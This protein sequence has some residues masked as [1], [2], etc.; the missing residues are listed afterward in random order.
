M[1]DTK[2]FVDVANVKVPGRVLGGRRC[3]FTKDLFAGLVDAELRLYGPEGFCDVEGK[4]SWFDAGF[5]SDSIKSFVLRQLFDECLWLVDRWEDLFVLLG[6]DEVSG[7]EAGWL[8]VFV[9][10]SGR[11]FSG[12]VFEGVWWEKLFG[13]VVRSCGRERHLVDVGGGRLGWP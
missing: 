13:F 1:A 12:S 3:E 2:F 4:P 6:E 7:W 10:G 9:E 11:G 5:D 8:R